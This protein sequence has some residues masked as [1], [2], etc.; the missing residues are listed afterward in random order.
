MSGKN[1][2]TDI[3]KQTIEKIDGAYAQATIR[4]YK[5]DFTDFIN[6]CQERGELA[7]PAKP[8]SVVEYIIK[9]TNQKKSS[10]TIRRAIAGISSIHKL[11]RFESPT[12]DPDVILEMRRM[13]RK[14]GRASNQALGVT[15]EILDK[16]LN[17]TGKDIRGIRDRALIL[18][19]YDTLCR[20]SELI[21]LRI[22]DI[23]TNTINGT[24]QT[25][26]NLRSS[27]TD[28][29][30]IGKWLHLSH[31]TQLALEEWLKALKDKQGPLF[32]GVSRGQ[33]ITVSLGP[34]QINRIYKRIAKSSQLEAEIVNKISGHSMRVGHA[35]DLVIA[36][37]SLPIIMNMGRWSK[38][39]TVMHYVEHISY[40]P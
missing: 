16:M 22:E 30:G 38:V 17:S 36:G 20:R 25:I 13:H 31:K 2:A 12:N 5:S 9:L 15:T 24:V 4:A 33:T 18:V 29:D 21:S 26:I 39:E 35:Q 10:A 14:L 32:R 27:K 8:I 6:F 3:L 19:A 11:N 1:I 40:A 34:G 7:L 37:A 23:K 28:Q